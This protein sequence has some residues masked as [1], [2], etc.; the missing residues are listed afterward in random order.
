MGVGDGILE[1]LHIIAAAMLF[2]A[3]IAFLYDWIRIFRRIRTRGLFWVSVEDLLYWIAVCVA[4]FYFFFQENSGSV[5]GYMVL[6]IGLGALLYHLLLGKWMIKAASFLIRKV[7]KQLKNLKKA[8]TIM[9][10]K[11]MK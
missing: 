5:R 3:G 7:K 10:E 2:G 9:V 4:A 8:V 6:G 1:E 11:R